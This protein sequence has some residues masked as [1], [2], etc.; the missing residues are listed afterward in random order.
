MSGRSRYT[1]GLVGFAAISAFLA[2][3]LSSWLG[4]GFWVLFG[5]LFVGFYWFVY[6]TA[7][8]KVAKKA[9]QEAKTGKSGFFSSVGK[10][11]V[12]GAMMGKAIG[13]AMGGKGSP[14]WVCQRCG[15][16][17]STASKLNYCTDC[18]SKSTFLKAG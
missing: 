8:G 9:S 10:S 14:N 4:G 15:L 11:A 5:I 12:G 18:K 17:K 13:D 1:D 2:W 7:K 3:I 6:G 16:V